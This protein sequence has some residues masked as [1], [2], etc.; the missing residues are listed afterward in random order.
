LRRVRTSG[1]RGSASAA[2]SAR[3]ISPGRHFWSHHGSIG[4]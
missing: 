2:V 4:P 3:A 1:Q